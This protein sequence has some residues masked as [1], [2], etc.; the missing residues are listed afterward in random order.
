MIE[1]N[2]HIL[3][4]RDSGKH[5]GSF[6]YPPFVPTG[7]WKTL[8]AVVFYPPFVPTGLW[9]TPGLLFSTHL[10]SLRDS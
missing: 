4:L 1:N 2:T 9:K 3:S 6:F 7:L 10:L 5:L 8:G